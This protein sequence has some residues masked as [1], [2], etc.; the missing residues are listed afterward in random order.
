LEVIKAA[1]QEREVQRIF[2]NAAIKKALC[3]DTTGDRSWLNKVRPY[4]GHDYH[5]HVRLTCPR[6][7]EACRE[8]DPVPPGDGCDESLAYWFSDA[9][10]HPKPS[11]ERPRPPLTM[12]QLPAECKAILTAR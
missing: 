2:V 4:Y 9:V 7:Q 12:A 6:G 1:A 10:L 3:R 8:Q 5:F 11:P